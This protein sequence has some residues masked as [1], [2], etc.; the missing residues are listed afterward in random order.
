MSGYAA[1][2]VV[3][4]FI[5]LGSGGK[6]RPAVITG[7]KTDGSYNAYPVTGSEP[8]GQPYLQLELADF[9]TGGLDLFD[10][11]YILVSVP[12]EIRVNEI[13]AKKGRLSRI[14]LERLPGD[15]YGY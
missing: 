8:A 1:G 10:Q 12:V 15:R 7:K 2:D 5:N 3:L 13:M 11:S 6:V 14:F 9:E 4:A